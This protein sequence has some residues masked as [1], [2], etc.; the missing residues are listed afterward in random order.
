[1][2]TSKLFPL[3]LVCLLFFACKNEDDLPDPLES[4]CD[5]PPMIILDDESR[6]FIPNAFSPNGDG[7]NDELRIFG[8]FTDSISPFKIVN[9]TIADI[10]GQLIHEQ[11][12]DMEFGIPVSGI[13]VWDGSNADGQILEGVYNFEVNV[14]FTNGNSFSHP[15]RVCSRV[16]APL[17][18]VDNEANCIFGTQH[19]GFGGYDPS[20]SSQ[21]DC[22]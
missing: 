17:P 19:N 8:Q 21:E 2:K 1:M 20:M 7:P 13:K 11:A 18:C 14:E 12:V 9:I 3:V 5:I 4:C 6:V 22:E 10:N 16:G 15:G